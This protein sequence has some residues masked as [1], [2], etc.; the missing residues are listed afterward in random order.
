MSGLTIFLIILVVVIVV[1]GATAGIVAWQLSASKKEDDKPQPQATPGGTE[2]VGAPAKATGEEPPPA[3]EPPAEEPPEEPPEDD[4]AA[5]AQAKMKLEPFAPKKV[6][7]NDFNEK[8]YKG[9]LYRT[10]PDHSHNL[11]YKADVSDPSLEKIFI[12]GGRPG[13]ITYWGSLVNSHVHS[14][15]KAKE[16]EIKDPAADELK[17]FDSCLQY[18]HWRKA[19]MFDPDSSNYA[20][21]FLEYMHLMAIFY[22]FF[23]FSG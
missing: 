20:H 11:F 14:S 3:G 2:E 1:G 22:D 4:L 7:D 16:I 21:R 12:S 19:M 17:K 18:M 6:D 9:G 13:K 15:G 8:V 5:P 10:K 23:L